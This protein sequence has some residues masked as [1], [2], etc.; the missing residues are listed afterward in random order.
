M[1][2]LF[3]Y[4]ASSGGETA[5]AQTSTKVGVPV[6]RPAPP[7][8]IQPV[9]TIAPAPM[10]TVQGQLRTPT[11]AEQKTAAKAA[12]AAAV[13]RSTTAGQA[14]AKA[15][16]AMIDAQNRGDMAAASQATVALSTALQ[17][18]AHAADEQ[19]AAQA[20][21]D[22]V[23]AEYTA[24]TAQR[25]QASRPPPPED[26]VVDTSSLEVGEPAGSI[27]ERYGQWLWIGGAVVGVVVLFAGWKLSHRSAPLKGYRKRRKSRR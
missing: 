20:V 16:S 27:F 19:A 26:H 1:G 18:A 10:Q 23:V 7:P 17:A 21:F 3:A 8:V 13:A 9:F 24:D 12:L 5:A 2:Q 4:G 25:K 14:A 6:V 22:H 15:Q 11:L